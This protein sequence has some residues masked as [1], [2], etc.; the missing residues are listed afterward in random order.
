MMQEL[1]YN[2]QIKVNDKIYLKDPESSEIGK[3][4][5]REGAEMINEMGLEA[6]TF[7]KLAIVLS[8]TES[9]IYRYFENKQKLLMYLI[10]WYWGWLE[11]EMV[12]SSINIADANERLKNT[13]ETICNPLKNKM[14]HEYFKLEALHGIIVEESLKAFLTKNVDFDNETGLFANYKRI[15]DRLI[16][17][18]REINSQY[19]FAN[20]LASVIIESVN[21]QRFIA[22]H[23]PKLTDI[24][25][26]GEKLSGFLFNMVISTI[27]SE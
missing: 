24:D 9:T 8:T 21:Q 5:I 27:L 18:I 15:H 13:I 22:R 7:K 10:S 4:I 12:L 17:H 16:G 25:R 11:Y 14:D 3:N 26:E 23:F 6:F 20:T 2:I 1:L 19:K